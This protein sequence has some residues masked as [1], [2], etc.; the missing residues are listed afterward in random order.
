MLVVSL[1]GMSVTWSP[2]Q[3]LSNQRMSIDMLCQLISMLHSSGLFTRI[4][5]A[6]RSSRYA[7]LPHGDNG[8]RYSIRHKISAF[9]WAPGL[10]LAGTFA[11]FS[12]KFAFGISILKT[13]LALALTFPLSL[14][15]IQATGATG[16]VIFP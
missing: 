3:A 9:S 8:E 5:T 1:T 6:V 12:M 15:A 11:I 16:T 7:I 4:A 14:V 2:I 13:L 10:L